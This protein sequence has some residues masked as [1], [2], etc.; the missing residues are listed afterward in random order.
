MVSSACHAKDAGRKCGARRLKCNLKMMKRKRY[1][2]Q[3][4]EARAR[5]DEAINFRAPRKLKRALKLRAAN[6]GRSLSKHILRILEGT[7]D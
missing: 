6:Q 2:T 1:V 4:A 5:S 3:R 7:E